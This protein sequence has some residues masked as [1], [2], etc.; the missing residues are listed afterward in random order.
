MKRISIIIISLI[1]CICASAQS[2]GHMKFMGI[3][4]GVSISSFQ[5]KLAAKGVKYDPLSRQL[6]DAVRLYHGKFAGYDAIIFVYYDTKTKIV[7]RAKACIE[8]STKELLNILTNEVS[9]MLYKKY[10]FDKINFIEEDDVY[11]VNSD[12]GYINLY[13][14]KEKADYYEHYDDYYMLHIDYF[15]IVAQNQDMKSRMDDL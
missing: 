1:I 14:S 12:E 6:K 15:D 7:Y 4:M 3:P 8:R 2:N 11:C 13:K 5:T 9:L 10:G